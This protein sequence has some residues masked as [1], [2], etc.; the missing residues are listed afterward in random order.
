LTIPERIHSVPD[1]FIS[2][3]KQL[4]QVKFHD[5]RPVCALG[6]F[7]YPQI[8][9]PRKTQIFTL[10]RVNRGAI[11]SFPVWIPCKPLLNHAV[12]SN[13]SLCTVFVF[14]PCSDILKAKNRQIVKYSVPEQKRRGLYR[15]IA[16]K[17]TVSAYAASR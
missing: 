17:R 13:F 1:F 3:R 4:Y 5:L 14:C 6:I 7:G 12:A 8:K 15:F 2:A 10:Q 16:L 9:K 11:I